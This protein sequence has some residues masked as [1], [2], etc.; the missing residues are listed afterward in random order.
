M[1]NTT[2]TIGVFI[3]TEEPFQDLYLESADHW[4]RADGQVFVYDND[5]DSPVAEIDAD[6]FVSAAKIS[7]ESLDD[8]KQELRTQS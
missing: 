8:A 3:Q 4:A 5:A 7:A 1:T 6:H 2:I